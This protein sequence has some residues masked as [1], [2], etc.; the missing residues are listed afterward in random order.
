MPRVIVHPGL[1]TYGIHSGVHP[2]QTFLL[3]MRSYLLLGL[4][5]P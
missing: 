2:A 4:R 1:Y 3:D 5:I